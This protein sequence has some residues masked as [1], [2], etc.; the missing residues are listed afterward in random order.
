MNSLFKLCILLVLVVYL[1]FIYLNI[2]N[3]INEYCE[4]SLELIDCAD[5]FLYLRSNHFMK[6]FSYFSFTKIQAQ[7]YRKQ[8]S[9]LV[10]IKF[11]LFR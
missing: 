11:K 9:Q 2:L 5:S 1:N 6:S 8:T 10:K 3:I 7:F 4:K